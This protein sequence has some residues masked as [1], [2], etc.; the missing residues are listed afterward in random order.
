[1]IRLKKITYEAIKS[2]IL[3]PANSIIISTSATIGEHALITVPHLPNPRFTSISLST[4]F[5]KRL[6]MK[7]VFYYCFILCN[8]CKENMQMGSLFSFVDMYTFKKFKIP[9]PS[10]AE[11]EK[12]ANCLTYLDDIIK[13][14]TKKITLLESHKKGL[15]Q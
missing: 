3:F 2:S 15:M 8:L 10:L 12:I 9:I 11:Q 14:C 1:M 4:N 7:F 13:S 5:I 6:D